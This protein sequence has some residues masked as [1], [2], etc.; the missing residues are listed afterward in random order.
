MQSGKTGVFRVIMRDDDDVVAGVMG[1]TLFWFD[2]WLVGGY[3]FYLLRGA[4]LVFWSGCFRW[5]F[6]LV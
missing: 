4:G 6:P 1:V 2:G 5:F 3:S